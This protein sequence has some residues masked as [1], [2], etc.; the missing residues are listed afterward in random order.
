VNDRPRT[1]TVVAD[2]PVRALVITG[3]N[4]QR[5]LRDHPQI[6]GKVLSAVAARLSPSESL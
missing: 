6:Q 5:L 1:A 4:F 3:R 2:T